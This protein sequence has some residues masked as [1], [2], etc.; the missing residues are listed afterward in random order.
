MLKL[1]KSVIRPNEGA[2]MYHRDS[3][4][5]VT[6]GYD[7]EAKVI[8]VKVEEVRSPNPDLSEDLPENTPTILRDVHTTADYI[9]VAERGFTEADFES[10]TDNNKWIVEYNSKTKTISD[11]IDV[12]DIAIQYIN[13]SDSHTKIY[14]NLNEYRYQNDPTLTPCFVLDKFYKSLGFDGSTV[15]F[16]VEDLQVDL[17]DSILEIPAEQV[18]EVSSKEYEF[19]VQYNMRLAMSFEILDVTGKVVSSP[20]QS[21]SDE[22]KSSTTYPMTSLFPRDDTGIAAGLIGPKN[23]GVGASGTRF[24]VVLPSSETYYVRV[25]TS[26]RIWRFVGTNPQATFDIETINGVC[27]KSRITLPN[28]TPGQTATPTLATQ[29]FI[30]EHPPAE[31]LT[32][33]NSNLAGSEDVTLKLYGLKSGDYIKMKVNC[34]KFISYAELWIEIQ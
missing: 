4:H 27:N 11:P 1:F 3:K 6:M 17:L 7:A 12:Y 16:F 28:Y 25:N 30:D 15:Q 29:Q 32:G 13:G 19:W 31:V 34:G 5:R 8:K 10:K 9:L 22:A 18:T 33:P 2:E 20:L 26:S 23:L 14:Y 24:K 21:V